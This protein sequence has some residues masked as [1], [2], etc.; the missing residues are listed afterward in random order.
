MDG[1]SASQQST[2]A[3][4]ARPACRLPILTVGTLKVGVSTTP[5]DE[6]PATSAAQFM[7]E[8]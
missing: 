8:R 2:F 1:S 5:D 6:L 7:A 4:M 3:Q